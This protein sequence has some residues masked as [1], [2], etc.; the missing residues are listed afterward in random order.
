MRL[1]TIFNSSATSSR[2]HLFEWC[3][4]AIT[5]SFIKHRCQSMLTAQWTHRL[6][7]LQ[8]T[9]PAELAADVISRALDEVSDINDEKYTVIDFC[10][11]AGGPIPIIEKSVNRF[12]AAQNAF[13]IPFRVSDIHPYIDNW[14]T[15]SSRSANLSFL[16]QPVDA[17]RAPAT[18]ISKTSARCPFPSSHTKIFHLFC[19][20]FHH[21]GDE[22][23]GEIVRN[24]LET[25]DGFAVVELQDR[26]VGT[27]LLMMGEGLLLMLLTGFWFPH[28]W[29]HLAFTY[30]IPVLPFVQMWDGLVSC[31]RT[32]TFVEMLRLVEMGLGEKVKMVQVGFSQSTKGRRA[33]EEVSMAVCGDW[34]FTWVRSL[35][36]WPF[37]YMNVI[38]GQKRT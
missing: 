35:H 14:L 5:P 37:G 30:W 10:S 29:L 12:R 7:L 18:V 13:P 20:S 6:P 1:G 17:T 32:R 25:S 23:A 36:T 31:L 21:F 19:L 28:D 27:L 38:I 8:T 3:D 16:P 24:M 11:G 4:L 34:S 22:D 9:S 15:I 2:W 33:G 26:C